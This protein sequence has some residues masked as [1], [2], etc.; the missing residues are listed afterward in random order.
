MQNGSSPASHPDCDVLVVGAGFAGLYTIYKLRQAGFSV[1]AFEAGADVGGTWW[2][3]R[4]PG[5]RCD[6]ESLD[7]CYGFDAELLDEWKWSERFAT[8]PEILRYIEHVAQRYD[9]RRHITFD[10][11]VTSAQWD[12]RSG[13]W[14]IGINS[15]QQVRARFFVSAAGGL[16]API[17]P[18]FPGLDTFEGD[19]YQ[20]SSWPAEDVSF[21][22]KRVGVIGTGS[23]GIQVIPVIAERAAHLTVFQRTANFTLPAVNRPVDPDYETAVRADYP[24]HRRKVLQTRAGT[25]NQVIA[26][27]VF[28]LSETEREAA[29]ETKWQRGGGGGITALFRDCFTNLAANDTAADFVRR[30]IRSIVKDPAVAEMLSPNDHPI[31]TKRICLDTDYYATFNRPNVT[32]VNIR[33]TPIERLTATGITTTDGEYPLDIIVFATGFDAITGPLLR[34]GVRGSGGLALE[35]AWRDGPDNYLGL[36]VAGFPN[37]FTITGPSSPAVLANVVVAIEQHVD[38]IARCLIHLRERGIDRIEAEPQAQAVWSGEV[39]AVAEGTLFPLAK[40]WYMGDNIPGKPRAFLAYVGGMPAYSARC[41]AVA[42]SDYEGFRMS[43]TSD[44]FTQREAAG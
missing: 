43:T 15:G 13:L 24:A 37:M 41:D 9:L 39:Q 10:A 36:A 2:W 31:A 20:T 12:D 29:F 28:D 16:S 34:M 14:T 38:W 27:S 6:V 8:Q 40:S 11:R 1:Q 3:N 35:D 22:G 7:Y 21:E 42:A 23:S 32:L 25:S 44:A 5:A 18:D 33:K 17:R 30:K 19:W 26:E 4:Y